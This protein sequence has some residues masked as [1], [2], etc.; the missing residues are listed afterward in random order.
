MLFRLSVVRTYRYRS[1]ASRMNHSSTAL[2]WGR[3]TGPNYYREGWNGILYAKQLVS[4]V[5]DTV[6][7]TDNVAMTAHRCAVLDVL[8]ALNGFETYHGSRRD[9]PGSWSKSS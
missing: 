3:N 1:S 7:I 8:I 6:A 4:S 9:M 2:Q 5:N